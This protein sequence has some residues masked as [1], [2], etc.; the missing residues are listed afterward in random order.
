MVDTKSAGLQLSSARLHLSHISI[1]YRGNG[2]G[3]TEAFKSVSIKE[4]DV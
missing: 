4:H 1:G 2:E 3:Y